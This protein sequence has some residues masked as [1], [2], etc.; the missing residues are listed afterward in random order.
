MVSITQEKWISSKRN[1]TVE[2]NEGWLGE[3]AEWRQ[4]ARLAS[5]PPGNHKRPASRGDHCPANPWYPLKRTDIV[6]PT[7]WCLKISILLGN[8]SCWQCQGGKKGSGD[9]RLLW[10]KTLSQL[11]LFVCVWI[12]AFEHVFFFRYG[13]VLTTS[14]QVTSKCNK[15]ILYI[16]IIHCK[17]TTLLCQPTTRRK[18]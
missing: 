4:G 11:V 7:L 17:H 5:A 1:V 3:R 6:L 12:Q 2:A 9:A 16:H 10:H 15:C 13:C 18:Q 14:G 8:L